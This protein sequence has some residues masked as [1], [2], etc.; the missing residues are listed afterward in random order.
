MFSVLLG[1]VFS[2][3]VLTKLN[4]FVK[5]AWMLTVNLV[6][7]FRVLTLVNTSSLL[8]RATIAV[9]EG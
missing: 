8:V 1:T 5:Y 2:M 3:K 9:K 4:K 6:T 7:M